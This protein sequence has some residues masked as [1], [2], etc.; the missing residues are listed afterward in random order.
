MHT[1][2][3]G[4]GLTLEGK[5]LLWFQ[6]L[7]NSVL[8]DFEVLIAAFIREHTKMGIQHNTLT[9]ILDLKKKEK[10]TVQDAIGRLK[11][12]ILRCPPRE[13]PKEDCLISCFLES[14]RD[15]NLYMQLFDQNHVKLRKCFDDALLYK[16]N[17]TWG[18]TN[19]QEDTTE[20]SSHTSKHLNSEAIFDIV[21]QRMRQEGK[22]NHMPRGGGYPQAYMCGI[23]LG[24][25]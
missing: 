25:I 6:S 19:V 17:C 3:Q 7:G 12:L 23:C 20:G 22:G 4:F 21:L 24:I 15:R 2:V 10:E 8:Y 16:D 18:G 9:Q 11:A 14:L 13:M 1:M 5:A